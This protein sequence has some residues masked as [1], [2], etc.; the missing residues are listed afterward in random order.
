VYFI[1]LEGIKSVPYLLHLKH[2]QD[3]HVD[4]EGTIQQPPNPQEVDSSKTVIPA[5]KR[6][7]EENQTHPKKTRICETST[8]HKTAA[9]TEEGTGCSH[10]KS[11]HKAI[12]P[13]SSGRNADHHD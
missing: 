7:L 10:H 9:N 6:K 3:L 4:V 1:S 12:I 11:Q 8:Y 2:Q 13:S 5:N